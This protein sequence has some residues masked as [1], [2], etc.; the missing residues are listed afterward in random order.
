MK[1]C[2]L[3]AVRNNTT[4]PE[5]DAVPH[6]PGAGGPEPSGPR[7]GRAAQ[8]PPGRLAGWGGWC[9]C[10]ARSTPAGML[11]QGCSCCSESLPFLLAD[12]LLSS[13]VRSCRIS[14]S[15]LQGFCWKRRGERRKPQSL[16]FQCL[17]S[18]T[19]REILRDKEI[20]MNLPV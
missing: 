19:T 11:L 7:E 12:A 3:M 5:K 10:G 14:C 4:A 9:V 17:S 20:C 6:G 13:Y 18:G 1:N 15:C 8:R 16:R 2:H